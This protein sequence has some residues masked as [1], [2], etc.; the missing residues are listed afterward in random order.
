MFTNAR[1]VLLVAMSSL[2][3][4]AADRP[5]LITNYGELPMVF[6]DDGGFVARGSHYSIQIQSD[7]VV[8]SLSNKN[9]GSRIAMRIE[10]GNRSAMARPLEPLGS[11]SNYYIGSDPSRWRVGVRHYGLIAVAGVLPGVDIQYYGS[12]SRLEYDFVVAPG[13]RTK[14]LRLRFD[15]TQAIG[16]NPAGDLVILTE[17]GEL[18]QQKPVAWQHI[19]ATRRP[20]SVRYILLSATEVALRID[21]FDRRYPLTVDPVLSYSTYLSGSENDAANAI[22]VDGSGN[23][24]IVG[25]TQSTNFPATSGNLHG[26]QNAFVTK[27]NATGTA[28]VYSTYLGGSE[29]DAAS[30]VAVDSQGNAYVAGVT[31]SPNFPIFGLLTGLTGQQNAF[32]TKLGPTG[33][34][35]YSRFIGGSASD[36]ATGVAVSNSSNAYVT[37]K[38]TSPDFPTTSGALKT[39]R[40]SGSSGFVTEVGSSAQ[41][42]YSTYI[43]GSTYDAPAAIQVDSDGNAYIA[44]QSR[45]SDFPTTAGAF[46]TTLKGFETGFLAKLNPA[47]SA[48]LYSTYI[49]GSGTDYCAGLQVDSSGYAYVIGSTNSSDFP[50]TTGAFSTAYTGVAMRNQVFVSKFNEDGTALVYSTYVGGSAGSGGDMGMGLAIDGLGDAY[51]TG[52]TGSTNFPNTAGSLDPYNPG[53][54]AFLFELNPL[55]TELLYS[56]YFGGSY[57]L[58]NAS[59]AIDSPGNIYLAGTTYSVDLPT[60][61]SAYQSSVSKDAMLPT[62]AFAAKVDFLT[63][64]L[65]NVTLPASSVNVPWSG[66]T[67]SF[68]IDVAAGCPWTVT[69]SEFNPLITL[70]PP[71]TG[72]GSGNVNYTVAI[73]NSINGPASATV[74]VVGG[75]LMAGTNVFTVYEAVGSCTDPVFSEDA[76]SFGS[77]G[78]TQSLN[79]TLPSGCGWYTT[80]QTG[81]ITTAGSIVSGSGVLE[82]SVP[83]NIFS[84]RSASF[85]IAGKPVTVSQSGGS[86]TAAVSG[87]NPVFPAKGGGGTVSLT[88]SAGTCSWMA[89]ALAPWIQIGPNSGSG[90]GNASIVFTVAINPGSAARSGMILAGDQMYEVMQAAG[91]AASGLNYATTIFAGSPDATTLGDGG[92]ATSA[93]LASVQG[94]VGDSQGNLYLSDSGRIRV[95]DSAGI[96]NTIAGGGTVAP[97]NGGPATSAA[98]GFPIGLA[99]DS[100]GNVYFADYT[101]FLVRKVSNGIITTVAGTGNQSFFGDGGPGTAAALNFPRGVAVDSAGNVYIGDSQ[102]CRIRMVNTSGTINTVA[103]T[104]TCTFNGDGLPA[105]QTNLQYPTAMQFDASGNLYFIDGYRVRKMS[106]GVITTEAGNGINSNDANGAAA[107]S[108]PLYSPVSIQLDP[109]GDIFIAEMSSVSE[110]TSDGILH[111]LSF[112]LPSSIASYSPGSLAMD[113]SGNLYD[114]DLYGYILEHTPVPNFCSYTVSTPLDIPS[115]AQSFGLSV[116]T[117]T[118]CSWTVNSFNLWITPVTKSGSGNGTATFNIASNTSS[119][120]RTGT[121]LIE[122]QIVSVTQVANSAPF[123]S[124]DL[125]LNNTMN[126]SGAVAVTGW[127]LSPTGIAEVSV[128][129]DPVAGETPAANGYIFIANADLVP[130]SRPDVAQAYPGYPDNTWGWGILVLTNELPGTGGLPIGNGS[131]RLH[132][133]VTDNAQLSTEIGATGIS[134]NNTASVLPFGTID[135]P[136]PGATASGTAYINFGWVLTPQPNIIPINGSTITVYIDNAPVG[137]P[138]YGYYRSDVS[139]LFPNLQNSA[140]PVGYYIVDTTQ[141]TNGLHTISW[142]VTDSAN[143][144]NGLGSRYFIVQN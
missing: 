2:A 113:T 78:G 130:G 5:S 63:P 121:L 95:I 111:D 61:P 122:G 29:V 66:F 85:T 17:A 39:S 83:P 102:N 42:I 144:S 18:I 99:V 73:N 104:G 45:S 141:L 93:Q 139:T 64:T 77:A 53:Q 41:I 124:L 10:G 31:S 91:P 69:T 46:Q 114:G 28:L 4:A 30:G 110:V 68:A 65:C 98:L 43:G 67:G 133:I 15:G 134:V 109:L 84:A 81:W 142:T 97:G 129:R 8:L 32:I 57:T 12:G 135:T 127:A 96:I 48:L 16:L 79:V 40:P 117:G 51:G 72:T 94:M 6:E 89:Y 60:T 87:A 86:C 140:G 92:P 24:Y 3:V 74:T 80:N 50:T 14:D 13:A 105:L 34:I 120:P 58:L 25:S 23:G 125:P 71:L 20:V 123:G 108:S 52:T 101:Q 7:G 82:V 100:H 136:A 35:A 22:A 55:G 62:S 90:T 27:L 9:S 143:D 132:V 118:G 107:T 54:D 47:G 138:S 21:K 131:Y 19:A 137:H 116:T 26:Q 56:T 76:I 119:A 37:G 112:S 88:T 115:T 75:A 1:P 70:L 126:V 33:A 128:W 38:T 11:Y 44:G 103:G 36:S 49:G 59:I 106:N